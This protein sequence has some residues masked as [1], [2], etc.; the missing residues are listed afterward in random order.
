MKDIRDKKIA[1]TSMLTREGAQDFSNI[2]VVHY[3]TSMGSA[4]PDGHVEGRGEESK[5]THTW[6]KVGNTWQIVG[7]MGGRLTQRGK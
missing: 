4:Y 7:G 1:F 6:I 5:I 3:R 2:V